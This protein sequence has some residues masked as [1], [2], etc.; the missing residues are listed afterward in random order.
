VHVFILGVS[1]FSE[2]NNYTRDESTT[3]SYA[4]PDACNRKRN[5]DKKT[6]QNTQNTRFFLSVMTTI[7]INSK[8]LKIK[9]FLLILVS[10]K[11]TVVVLVERDTFYNL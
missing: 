7:I 8:L 6:Q 9:K 11:M 10:S 4:R 2:A 3:I 1:L 5:L